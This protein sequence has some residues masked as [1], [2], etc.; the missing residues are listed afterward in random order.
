MSTS[1]IPKNLLSALTCRKVEGSKNSFMTYFILSVPFVLIRSATII[2]LRL[3]APDYNLPADLKI[4]LIA[5][6]TMFVADAFFSFLIRFL[7]NQKKTPFFEV[8]TMLA[9][10][11][12]YAIPFIVL[13]YFLS[14]YP[15]VPFMAYKIIK[16][17]FL[18]NNLHPG[19]EGGIGLWIILILG[20]LIF[21]VNDLHDFNSKIYPDFPTGYLTQVEID[22]IRSYI[23]FKPQND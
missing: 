20:I 17:A 8:M 7:H 12:V 18:Y 5:A 13:S 2:L 11:K 9:Y 6:L 21:I 1:N 22:S 14:S 10:G 23:S 16:G 19:Y 4:G 15:Y 3:K